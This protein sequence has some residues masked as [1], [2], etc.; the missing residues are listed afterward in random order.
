MMTRMSQHSRMC[1]KRQQPSQP[2]PM[3]A[4]VP[5]SSIAAFQ[6]IAGEAVAI[7]RPV[8]SGRDPD[9]LPSTCSWHDWHRASHDKRKQRSTAPQLLPGAG[10]AFAIVKIMSTCRGPDHVMQARSSCSWCR[11]HSAEHHIILHL[12]QGSK[13]AP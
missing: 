10:E 1:L 8:S 2:W 5:K 13:V 4:Q 12:R 7:C 3:A 11:W 6:D 9:P